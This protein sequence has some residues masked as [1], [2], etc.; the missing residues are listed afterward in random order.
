LEQHL[1]PRWQRYIL[2]RLREQLGQTQIIATTH[3]PLVAA[4]VADLSRAQVIRLIPGSLRGVDVVTIPPNE[5][6]GKRSDQVLAD[7]FG[8][9]TTKSP[10]TIS[11]IDRYSE[12]LGLRRGRTE[13]E[14]QELESLKRELAKGWSLGNSALERQA[15]S[16]VSAVLDAM[17]EEGVKGLSGN[18]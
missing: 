13:S 16:A 15:D 4:G 11:K 18:S 10:G 9:V 14:E 12:L 5:L 7:A 2:L 1:H 6:S 3:T 8:L 17:I